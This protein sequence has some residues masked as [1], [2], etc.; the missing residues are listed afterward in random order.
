MLSELTGSQQVAKM[1]TMAMSILSS[2]RL[3]KVSASE[4]ETCAM[5]VAERRAMRF[6][7]SV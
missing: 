5:P 6:Q 3:L 2:R 1:T 4:L 7:M